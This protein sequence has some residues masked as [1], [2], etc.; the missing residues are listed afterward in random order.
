VLAR[1]PATDEIRVLTRQDR[2]DAGNVRYYRGD[3]L[4]G[5][6]VAPALAGADVV[7]H[8][9]GAAKGDDSV[10]RH[11]IAAAQAAGR[12][13]IVS[14]SVI[15]AD[16]VPQTGWLDRSFFGYFG[17]K[18]DAEK[19]IEESGLPWTILRAS[20]F[21]QLMLVVAEALARL[22]VIPAPSRFRV[23]PVDA[24]DVAE[25]LVALALGPARGHVANIAGPA[26]YD[27]ADLIRTYLV[28][29]G[30]HRPMLPLWLPGA[31]AG[32]FR[33]GANIDPA[34]ATG[35]VT[36]DQALAERFGG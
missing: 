11:L 30:T 21:H 33:A 10:A 22:P 5:D 9:A 6:G 18:R 27:I 1:L 15:G 23:Q 13:H 14:I 19:A 24:G 8:C 16:R 36:W 28:A 34:H 4:S 3:L 31:A 2:E 35:R 20:Q 7:I 12:P 29:S 26:V 17:A 32:A 25:R